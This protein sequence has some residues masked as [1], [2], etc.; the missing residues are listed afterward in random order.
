MTATRKP[1]SGAARPRRSA[2]TPLPSPK[3]A[4][5]PPATPPARSPRRPTRPTK[6]L[7]TSRPGAS[8]EGFAARYDVVILG[9]GMAGLTLA[10]QLQLETGV[11]VLVLDRRPTLPPREQKVGEATVQLSAFYLAKVLDL[12]EHL[13]HDHLMKYN[14]RF[15]WKSAERDNR[16]LEDYS[17]AYIR[18]LSNIAS[19]QLDRNLLEQE[20]LALLAADPRVSLGYPVRQI[21][22]ELA[23]RTSAAGTPG[24][25]PPAP[26][27]PTTP[28]GAPEAGEADHRVRFLDAHGELHEVA[29]GWVVD[30]TGRARLLARRLR[31]ERPS[32]I[33]HGAY[34]LW[35]DGNLDVE[36]L[37]DR[38]L[39]E[40]RLAPE[41]AVVGHLPFALATNHFAGEGFWFWVIP[42]RDDKTSLGLVFDRARVPAAAVS[43]ADKLIAWICEQFPLLAR[44]LPQ[45]RVLHATGLLDFSHSCVQTLSPERW[46]ITGEAGR[47]LDPLYSPGGD[48][49]AIHN[50]LIV[51]AMRATEPAEREARCRRYEQLLRAVFDSFV[52]SYAVTYDLLGDPEAFSLKYT[53]E[54]TIYFGFYVFPFV[55]ELYLDPRGFA[56]YVRRLAQIGPR[57]RALQAFLADYY[58]WKKEHREAPASPSY[59][60]F[61]S[62]MP[63]AR[64]EKTFYRVGVDVDTAREVLDEQLRNLDDLAR[65]FVAHV[66][67]VV[68]D[69][70]RIRDHQGFV[71]GID[72]DHLSFDPGAFAARWA[73]VCNQEGTWSWGFAS[74]PLEVFQGPSTRG[75]SPSRPTPEPMTAGNRR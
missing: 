27:A 37:T 73:S 48:F 30:A 56:A 5:A 61:T 66:A 26:A 49:I 20:L 34:F 68:L 72:L 6:R 67:S 28:D 16:A 75:S 43:S 3:G 9:A 17:Q 52:P 58:R 11:S 55:N 1:T 69:E 70:P 19:Y 62:V 57:N 63:L 7:P 53:W 39:R 13:V 4:T 40:R 33:R 25:A 74:D 60:D 32:P 36:R 15:Y 18:N 46:A 41:R 65:F 38:S 14:L 23:T 29:A 47:F 2:P 64:A 24:T 51:D 54:L 21:E 12:E 59:F 71:A 31:L 50:T 10:R 42:L 35:V 8:A 45:R 44:D 22:V